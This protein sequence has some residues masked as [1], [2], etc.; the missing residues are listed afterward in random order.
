M[1]FAY[2]AAPAPFGKTVALCRFKERPEATSVDSHVLVE[3]I[4]ASPVEFVARCLTVGKFRGETYALAQSVLD[5]RTDKGAFYKL[6]KTAFAGV[7][8]CHITFVLPVTTSFIMI[9]LRSRSKEIMRSQFDN[10]QSIG[11]VDL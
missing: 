4:G 1:R 9:C 2:I 8:L 11:P 5:S 6:F 3:V 10:A 7:G